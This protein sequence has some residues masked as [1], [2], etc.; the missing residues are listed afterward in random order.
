VTDKK[1]RSGED[2]I[3]QKQAGKAVQER[4]TRFRRISAIT[5]DIA[6]SCHTLKSGRFSLDWIAGAAERITG[7]S[8]QEIRAHRSL[9]F[10]VVEEDIPLFEKNVIGLTPGSRGSCELRIRH[11]NG[12]VVWVS[13]FAECVA[14]AKIPGRL[15]YGGLAEITER[16]QVEE[17][18]SASETRYRRLFE[19]A[20]DGILI[21]DAD[22]GMIMDVNPFLTEMLGFSRE[23]FLGKHIWDLGFFKGIVANEADFLKLRQKEYIRYEDVALEAADGRRINVEFVSNLY[24]VGQGKVIQCSLRHAHLASFPAQNPYPVVEVEI[25]GAVRFANPAALA[26]LTRLGLD[27]D[28]RQFLPGAPAD[29]VLLR[30]HCERNPQTD[31]LPLGGEIFVRVVTAPPGSDTLHVYLV[32]ITERKQV[33]EELRESKKLLSETEKTAH[34]GGW[35][36]DAE[37]L[38]Q[39]WTEETFRILEIDV[40]KGEPKVPEGVDFIAPAFRPM[41][42]QGIRRALEFGEPYDQE[43][44]VITAKGNRKWVHAVAEAYQEQGKTKRVSGTFQDITERKQVEAQLRQAQKMEAIGTLA[45]GVAH[46]FN[47]LL[48]GI[49]GNVAIMRSDLPS[50]DPLVANLSAVDSA[51]RQ[52]AA[53]T[54]GLLTFSRREAVLPMPINLTTALEATLALLKQSL[55]AT[56]NIVRDYEQTAWNV[57]MDQSQFMQILLNLGV[58]A[59]D[60][61]NGKGT[62]TIGRRNEV[63]E[64]KYVQ[65]HPYAR[66]GEFVHLSVTDTGSGMSAE[67]MRHLFEPFY[68]T[69]PV[70]S[71]TGLGLAI[72]YGAVKQ[73][74]GWI[75]VTSTEGVG[76]T[77]D[78]YV[79]RCLED[80]VPLLAPAS[81]PLD[82]GSGTILV[83]EDEPIVCA[84]AQALLSKSGYTV[85]TAPDGASALNAL[86]EHP[87]DIDLILLD[88][89]M[90]GM[91]TDEIVQAMRTL[92]STVRILLTSG[93]TPG[94]TV[95]RMLE[96]RSVQGFLAKPYTLA[97]LAGKVQELLHGS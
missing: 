5:S 84:V 45:G 46:D 30:S 89:T 72:V 16:K 3:V 1:L 24:P 13:S 40:T 67:V 35:V 21:L 66:T 78:I 4:Q 23:E 2:S 56:I 9:R 75:T 49:L 80:S 95:N 43:W 57:L 59:H 10:L 22:T 38:T 74:G 73:A 92:N 79:P 96:E 64:E 91:T 65:A 90:P 39:K 26:T 87:T 7:Y 37:K 36:F 48:T 63:V 11:K 50:S 19:A 70:G 71:G 33:E 60:A 83:V 97:E 29:L 31:E 27:P 51:A 85:M 77:F 81:V 47:N 61:M 41:A 82:V 8:T 28:V 34:I 69:K 86:R 93:Y 6:Y 68:T 88:M 18:L 12:N 32:D 76:T 20:K 54:K 44:E 25:D 58:N 55:P 14:A 62:L 17:K 42:E 94:D 52:A 15:L 53:L